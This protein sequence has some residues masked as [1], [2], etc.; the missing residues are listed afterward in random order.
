MMI[1]KIFAC[2]ISIGNILHFIVVDEITSSKIYK[3]KSRVVTWQPCDS[4]PS[5]LICPIEFVY[6]F[7]EHLNSHGFLST[8]SSVAFSVD[9]KE[10]LSVFYHP[11]LALTLASSEVSG[12]CL[13]RHV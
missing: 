4:N 13:D 9:R 5:A 1:F 11:T 7:P 12:P 8:L 2:T 3:Y 6:V 10:P